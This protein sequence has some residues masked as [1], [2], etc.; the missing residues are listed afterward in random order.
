MVT[1]PASTDVFV[2]GG[3]PAG[4]ALAIA[5]RQR[6]LSVVVADG[7]NPPIDKTCG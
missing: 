2:V 1:L 6:G 5:A 3:G 7:A 4:L